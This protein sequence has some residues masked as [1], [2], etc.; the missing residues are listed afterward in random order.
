M[1]RDVTRLGEQALGSAGESSLNSLSE[2]P[3]PQQEA[4]EERNQAQDSSGKQ[5][6]TTRLEEDS[7]SGMPISI[8]CIAET[9]SAGIQHE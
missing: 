5:T 7:D 8:P 2:A 9:D 3:P 4:F 1:L 6:S